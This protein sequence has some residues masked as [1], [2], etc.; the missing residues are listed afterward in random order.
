MTISLEDAQILYDQ[1]RFLQLFQETAEYWQPEQRLGD[2]SVDELLLGGRLARR[3]GGRRLSRWLFRA[4]LTRN[5]E[6]PRVKYFT[7]GLR[8]H[9]RWLFEDLRSWESKPEIEGADAVTQASWL[10]AQGVTWASVRDF[11]RAHAS[12]ERAKSL[13]TRENWVFSCESNVSAMEDK[14]NEALKSAEIA[15]EINPGAP[16]A[17]HSLGQSLLRLQRIEEAAERLSMAA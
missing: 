2:L 11:T 6:H 1:N 3:L 5:P 10:A 13:V 12:I 17:A 8:Q 15:W 9:G 7:Y 14:W 4:A 16:Y